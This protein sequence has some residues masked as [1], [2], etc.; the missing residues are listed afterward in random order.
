MPVRFKIT[1]DGKSEGALYATM[2]V[3]NE[4]VDACASPGTDR[5]SCTDHATKETEKKSDSEGSPSEPLNIFG[6]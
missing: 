5:T 2:K 4:W 1:A 6:N 3:S